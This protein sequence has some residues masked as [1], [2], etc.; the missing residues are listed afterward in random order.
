LPRANR[1]VVLTIVAGQISL[2]GIGTAATTGIETTNQRTIPKRN[3]GSSEKTGKVRMGMAPAAMV[4][5][6]VSKNDKPTNQAMPGP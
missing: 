5:A 3:A 2:I 6:V 4:T 1:R